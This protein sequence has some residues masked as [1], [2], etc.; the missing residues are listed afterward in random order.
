M[1]DIATDIVGVHAF[2]KV[3][4]AEGSIQVESYIA[5]RDFDTAKDIQIESQRPDSLV[6]VITEESSRVRSIRHIPGWNRC[7][8]RSAQ[9]STRVAS[10]WF[11]GGWVDR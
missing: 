4:S 6:R 5:I 10:I 8:S 11:Q 1:R 3:T 9:I 7:V 2:A